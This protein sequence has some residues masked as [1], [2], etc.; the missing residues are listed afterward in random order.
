[1]ASIN[2]FKHLFSVAG[3]VP[4]FA[5]LLVLTLVTPL[6]CSRVADKDF[7]EG[8]IEYCIEFEDTVAVS[9]FNANMRPNRMV[10][11]F[12]DNNTINKVEGLSGAFSFAF[13]QNKKDNK[14]YTLI[15]L[16]NKKL[17]YQEAIKS[18]SYPFAYRK[19]PEFIIT[20]TTDYIEY[21]GYNCCVAK[22]I[23][24]DST[25]APFDIY[26]TNEIS[27]PNPNSNTPFHQIE[28]VM[29]KFSTVLFD[30]R[31]DVWA[32]TIKSSKISSDEFII[33][34]DYEEIGDDVLNELIEL[35]K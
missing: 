30:Q 26:Y 12:K 34:P 28:G 1:M 19:M 18:N 25:K 35:I 27:I 29:L 16:L 13:I 3:R 2:Y 11:K 33:T 31:M 15:K 4:F 21:L 23:F 24:T 22:A 6:G 5:I 9:A 7:S 17:F 10:I 20:K 14:A 8:F 32:T